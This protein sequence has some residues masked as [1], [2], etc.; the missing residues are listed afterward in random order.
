MC[1]ETYYGKERAYTSLLVLRLFARKLKSSLSFLA[2]ARSRD[3]HNHDHGYRDIY[4]EEELDVPRMVPDD[5]K[6]GYFAVVAAKGYE[7]KRFIVKLEWLNNPEFLRLLKL[8]EEEYGFEQIGALV[9]PCRPEE[10]ERILRWDGD[11]RRN[12][13]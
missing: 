7:K 10:L 9:V 4:D 6:E 11:E 2:G 1:T 3:H 13:I 8:A 5:V 12:F